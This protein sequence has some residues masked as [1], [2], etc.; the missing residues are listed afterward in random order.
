MFH[1]RNRTRDRRVP[2]PKRSPL[3]IC[4]VACPFSNEFLVKVTFGRTRPGI[5]RS[6]RILN[7]AKPSITAGGMKNQFQFGPSYKTK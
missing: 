6:R 7:H 5:L 3:A 4:D 1:K 2:E